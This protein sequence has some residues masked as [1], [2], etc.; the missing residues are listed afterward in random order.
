MTVVSTI[1]VKA[2]H[3]Y[4]PIERIDEEK[5]TVTA[6]GFVNETVKGEGG[7]ILSRKAMEAATPDYMKWANIRRMHSP[8][9]SGK[10][11]SVIWDEKGARM[12][13][14]IVDDQDWEKVKRGVYKGLSVGVVPTKMTGKRVESCDWVETS[15]VDR[16]KDPD[17]KIIAIRA[18]GIEDDAEYDC[19]L[20][21]ERADD[22]VSLE[23]FTAIENEK[24]DL[25]A[26]LEGAN[27][28]IERVTTLLGE[29]KGKLEESETKLADSL[30]R[31][32]ELSAKA[33]PIKPPVVTV[34]EAF[35]RTFAANEN[36]ASETAEALLTEYRAIESNP[37]GTQEEQNSKLDRMTLIR[38]QLAREGVMI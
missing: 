6:Y 3:E 16:P 20:I 37:G 25:L 10:A 12:D 21:E 32:E 1:K 7:V 4:A 9:A 30:K 18:D 34:T 27:A 19:Q 31:Y 29:T 11:N 35:Q 26:R 8:H 38:L 28:E 17:A 33:V 36:A 14:E 23:R 24:N 5:R 15:L 22:T 2:I 13:I